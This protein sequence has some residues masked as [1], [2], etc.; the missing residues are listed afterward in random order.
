MHGGCSVA[1]LCLTIC[2]TMDSS[3]PGFLVH[4]HIKK[5]AQ[6]HVHSDGDDIKTSCPLLSASY[7]AFSLSQHQG[8]FHLSQFFDQVGGQSIGVSTS[9]SVL[10]MNIQDWFPSGL[11][12]L[13]SLQ[14]RGLSR[15]YSNITVQKHQFF[16]TQLS[17]WSNSHPY[18]TNGKTIALTRWTFVSKVMCLLFNMLCLCS[19]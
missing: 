5:M 11:T 15:F 7:S 13:I 19:S 1:Q 18:M 17:L 6:F 14:S 9:T 2:N 12:G 16:G 10:P 3:M 4:H 8:L